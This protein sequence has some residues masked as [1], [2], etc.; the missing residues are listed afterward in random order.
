MAKEKDEKL[1]YRQE[2]QKL[3]AEGQRTLYLLWGKEDY[4]REQYL[5]QLK[6]LCIPE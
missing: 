6:A 1:N 2:L 4:L 3:K 5:A